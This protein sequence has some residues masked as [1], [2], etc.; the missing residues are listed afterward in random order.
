MQE[1]WPVATDRL[2][3]VPATLSDDE[4]AMI[5]PLAVA[6]HDVRRAQVNGGDAVVVIGGGPIGALIPM[7]ARQ[8]RPRAHVRALNPFRVELLA[9]LGID[10]VG[11]GR[12]P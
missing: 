5:E 2:L 6:A 12:D 11:P 3:S 8:H 10:R 9:K 7:V 4:A 1:F